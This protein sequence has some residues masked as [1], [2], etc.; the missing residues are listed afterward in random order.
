LQRTS[1]VYTR[2]NLCAASW[3]SDRAL[4]PEL[5][6]I[7]LKNAVVQMAHADLA[8]ARTIA[9]HGVLV[10]GLGSRGFRAFAANE[11]NELFEQQQA[12]AGIRRHPDVIA[13]RRTAPR[14][15]DLNQLPGSE[16][17][18][19]HWC[20]K[21]VNDGGTI[22]LRQGDQEPK[23]RQGNQDLTR[24]TTGPADGNGSGSGSDS[25]SDSS[26]HSAT[27]PELEPEPEPEPEPELE[28][29]PPSSPRRPAV[30]KRR[31]LQRP[32]RPAPAP[33]VLGT[34]GGDGC[35]NDDDAAA[36]DDALAEEGEE[37]D[38]DGIPELEPGVDFETQLAAGSS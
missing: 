7:N 23:L 16:S 2:Y 18:G 37:D 22:L 24:T 30:L 36:C 15:D 34:T 28:P 12:L 10:P 19:E 8:Q 11:A 21:F 32:T 20:H 25:G 29:E 27:E 4:L 26:F 6:S 5:H 9:E 33:P 1:C 13:A 3:L 35:E 17:T 31:P 14:F 38:N